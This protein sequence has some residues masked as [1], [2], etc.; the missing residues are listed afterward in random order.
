MRP[1]TSP[2]QPRA[3][4][5]SFLVGD[6]TKNCIHPFLR[7]SAVSHVRLRG[8]DRRDGAIENCFIGEGPARLRDR[9]RARPSCK[10]ESLLTGKRTGIIVENGPLD[11]IFIGKSSGVR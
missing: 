9:A 6:I 7:N 8:G 3:F 11:A 2:R 4:T 5:L 10:D 1:R